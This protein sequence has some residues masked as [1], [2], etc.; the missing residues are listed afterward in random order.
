MT[1]DFTV[2]IDLEQLFDEMSLELRR[3]AADYLISYASPTAVNQA[4]NDC[5]GPKYGEQ[6][7]FN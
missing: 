3:K 7:S 5:F 2:N 1:Q 4:Y 6:P